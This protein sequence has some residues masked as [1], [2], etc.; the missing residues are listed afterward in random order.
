[1]FGAVLPAEARCEGT[2]V[3]VEHDTLLPGHELMGAGCGA[4]RCRLCTLLSS[5]ITGNTA[6]ERSPLGC[7]HQHTLTC[8]AAARSC[9][10]GSCQTAQGR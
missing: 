1:M 10:G 4:E 8:L 3:G 2:L 9:M 6:G 5:S 7:F